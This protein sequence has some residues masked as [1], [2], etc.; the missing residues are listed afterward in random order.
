MLFDEQDE[1]RED[2]DWIE[3][4]EFA[5]IYAS[6]RQSHEPPSSSA[7]PT[8]T[9]QT[10]ITTESVQSWYY[11]RTLEIESLTGLV[12][13]ALSFAELGIV[14]G[15]KNMNE[16]IENLRTLYTLVYECSRVRR[17]KNDT[18]DYD[19]PT[20]YTLDQVVRLNDLERITLIMSHAYETNHDLYVKNLQ[21]WLLPFVARQST[22]KQREALLKG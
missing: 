20:S 1:L 12:D 9:S 8:Q 18:D 7:A 10:K 2:K 6:Y 21:E 15:C 19:D 4:E 11:N 13:V 16:L 3:G 17:S 22:L 14:N 5:A